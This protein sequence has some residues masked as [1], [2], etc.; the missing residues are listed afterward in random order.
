MKGMK[1]STS[2]DPDDR[3]ADPGLVYYELSEVVIPPTKPG[4]FCLVTAAVMSCGLCG[5]TIS[6]S[7]GPGYGVICR[8]CGEL[9]LAGRLRSCVQWEA[10]DQNAPLSTK[11]ASTSGSSAVVQVRLPDHGGR[12]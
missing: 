1:P 2:E 4:E 11:G 3:A 12:E 10:D 5:S 8:P 7:G 6:G 9:L